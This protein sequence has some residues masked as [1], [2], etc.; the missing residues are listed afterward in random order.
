M[1]TC[2][3]ICSLTHIGGNVLGEIFSGEVLGVKFPG[4]KFRGRNILRGENS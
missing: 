3:H 4:G 1:P 2:E